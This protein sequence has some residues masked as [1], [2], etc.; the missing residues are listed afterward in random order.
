M[1][2]SKSQDT[3]FSVPGAIP[4]VGGG[5]SGAA[6]ALTIC[7]GG[8]Q[9]VVY[10]KSPFPRHKVCGEFFSP[11]ILPLL[12]R[13]G[14]AQGFLAKRPARVNQVE[15]HFA[16]TNRKFP[17][18]DPGYSLSRYTFDHFLLETAVSRGT[19][20]RR[21]RAADLG[22]TALWA[23]GRSAVGVRGRR[24]F[25]FKAHFSG[26]YNDLV[27]LYFFPGGYCGVSPVEEGLTNICGLATERTLCQHEFDIDRLLQS[28]CQLAERVR[29]LTR[30]TSWCMAGPLSFGSASL[31]SGDTLAA[32]D[33]ACFIDPFTGSGLLAAVQTGIWAGEAIL[34]AAQGS[35]WPRCCAWYRRRCSAFYRR[36]L[37]ATTM[38]RRALQLG[39]AE[40][41]AGVV[42]GWLLFRLTRPARLQ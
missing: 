23:A 35:D 12:E 7:A 1:V 6:A 13:I 8:A 26:P 38:I 16:R 28:V 4:I 20:L 33:A 30:R 18:P 5:P 31:P 36:Q 27:E 11:E 24:N 22:S 25:G 15:L 14:V 21:E 19:E 40:A 2:S 41:L 32:G 10:E 37:S 34:R 29:P 3:R 17:L 9:P 42:P 39:W